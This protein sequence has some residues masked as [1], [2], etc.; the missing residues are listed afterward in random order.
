[1]KK[2]PFTNV[3]ANLYTKTVQVQPEEG[4]LQQAKEDLTEVPFPR[5]EVHWYPIYADRPNSYQVDLMFEPI[6]N[7]KQEK[8]LQALLTC[9]NINTK[10]AFC[11]PVDYTKKLSKLEDAEFKAKVPKKIPVNNKDAGKVLTAFKRIQNNMQGE[12]DVLNE[13]LGQNDVHFQIDRVYVDEG[14][15]FKGSFASYCQEQ[16]IHIVTFKKNEGSKRRMAVVERFHRTL[17][18]L[19]YTLK[20]IYPTQAQLKHN[21]PIALDLYNRKN[22]HK[23]LQRFFRSKFKKGERIVDEHRQKVRYFPAMMVLPGMEEEYIRWKQ[24]QENDVDDYYKEH[25]DRLT[26]GTEVK[27]YKRSQETNDKFG[28]FGGGTLSDVVRISKEHRYGPNESRLGPSFELE[29]TRQ[30]YLP[31]E[32]KLVSKNKKS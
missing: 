29:G 16:K 15:E 17:R 8:I 7:A 13:F 21:I 23:E 11:E 5:K 9:V 3:F 28:K 2:V 26:P 18:R 25:L 4:A 22:N 19:L 14:G 6:K 20:K 12:A 31:Y 24:R 32:L 10:Y 1:M 30:R 27:Y